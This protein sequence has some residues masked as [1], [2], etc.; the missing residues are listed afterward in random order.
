MERMSTSENAALRERL[1]AIPKNERLDF[2]ANLPR[3]ELVR[4]KRILPKEDLRKLTDH[5]D[6]LLRASRK[7]TL[8]SWLA[9]ARA[10]RASTPEAMVE[11]LREAAH[12]LRPQDAIWLRRIDETAAAGGFSR[13]QQQVIRGIYERYFVD[14]GVSQASTEN[15]VRFP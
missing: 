6:R 8:E 1:A 10:G 2:L 9:E 7:P 5:I 13:R 12:R 15:R 3:E 4:F 14:R 11:V